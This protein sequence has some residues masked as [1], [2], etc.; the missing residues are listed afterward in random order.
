MILKKLK[1]TMEIKEQKQMKVKLRENKELNLYRCA[2]HR[3]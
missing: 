2:V 3:A 1:G